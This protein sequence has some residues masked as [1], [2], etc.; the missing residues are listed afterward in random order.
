MKNSKKSET[1]RKRDK[2]K[3]RIKI[4]FPETFKDIEKRK[5]EREK[6]LG[7]K[8]SEVELKEYYEDFEKKRKK[9]IEENEKVIEF[10]KNALERYKDLFGNNST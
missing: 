4:A 2:I 1:K 5:K 6:K 9:T 8:S 3:K 7:G 10:A